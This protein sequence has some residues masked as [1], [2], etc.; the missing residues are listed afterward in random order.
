MSV[1]RTLGVNGTRLTGVFADG[2]AAGYVE[3]D[4]NRDDGPRTSRVGAWVDV[5]SLWVEPASRRRGVG[6]RLL[7]QA[8]AWLE[9]GGVTRLLDYTDAG[10]EVY[11]AFL[12]VAGFVPL[13]CT[14]RRGFGPELLAS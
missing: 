8:A 9:L 2:V 7:G 5:G 12:T 3:V 14:R 6:T 4:T 11:Q 13:S 1:R 10:D